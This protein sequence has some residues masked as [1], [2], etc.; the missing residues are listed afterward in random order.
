[1][2]SYKPH[3]PRARAV[4]G[5]V[6]MDEQT[7]NRW[8]RLRLRRVALALGIVAAAVGAAVLYRSPLLR[9][10]DVE[11]VGATHLDPAQLAQMAGL[12][13]AS[14]FDPPLERAESRIAALPPV[15]SV[16]A[17]RHWPNSVRIEVVERAPWGLWII[18]E[19][20]YVVDAE[21]VVLEGIPPPEGAPVINDLG[22]PA[23]LIPGDRVDVDAVALAQSLLQRLPAL[24]MSVATFEYTPQ[25]G[26]ALTTD[27]NYRVVVGDSQNFE[28]K[29]AVWQAIDRELGREAMAGHVLDLRF[30]SR[31]SFQ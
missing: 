6:V 25:A 11:V 27:A 15:L 29:M 30:E 3:R 28:Y 5:H 31:P 7:R 24:A 1:M 20:P 17:E 14:M 19:T 26:L 13:G 23:K 12:E 10:Q 2:Y 9:V 8:R 22:G 4:R 16:K 18:G 21:G